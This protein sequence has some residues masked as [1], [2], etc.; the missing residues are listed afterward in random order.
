MT[1]AQTFLDKINREHYTLHK[2]YEE[3]FWL[4]YMGDHSV[5]EKM[6]Q[7]LVLRDAFRANLQHL[8]KIEELLLEADA[9]TKERLHIWKEYFAHYQ[10]TPKASALKIR[11]GKLEA[12]VHKKLAKR[13]EGYVDPYTQKFVKASST[14]M[15]TLTR[16]HDDERVRKACFE[17][18][19]GLATLCIPEYIQ[20]V[21]LRNEYVREKGY[22]DFYDYKL[23]AEDKITKKELFGLFDTLYTKTKSSFGELKKLAKKTPG[24]L[25]PW[26]FGYYMTGDFTKEEDPYFQF[27]DALL[28]WGR[29]FAAL[30]IDFKGAELTL[31][32]L[33]REGKYS[34]G[35]CHWPKLVYYKDGVRQSGAAGFTCNVVPGQVGAGMIGYNT[36]FH[37][38][39]HA[40]HLT[41]TEERECCLNHEYY[42]STASWDE[43]QSMFCDTM[44]DSIEW[45]TRYAKNAEGKTY[46]LDLHK[47]ILEKTHVLAPLELHSIAFVCN[48]ERE[49]YEAQNLTPEAV[50]EI[51]RKNYRKFNGLEEDS[52]AALNVPHIYS[53]ES[54]ASYH[55]YG[56]AQLAVYQW[57]EYFYTKYGYIVDN[58][59]VGKEMQKVWKYGGRYTFPKFVE[60]ATGKPLSTDAFLL[61]A[62]QPISEILKTAEERI[63]RLKKVK[64]YT[65]PVVLNAKIRLVDGK[66]EIA[67]NKRGFEKMTVTY[68]GWLKT[69]IT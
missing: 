2:K 52:L 16:T 8:T 45:R 11:I 30:G 13:K 15:R 57:R 43:V 24:L 59:K 36:L 31:D 48:F 22:A 47:R 63:A 21:A 42:P 67:N 9:K 46:P 29:S 60:M 23:Q 10:E 20:L 49:I 6:G 26:N 5:D 27:S 3:L 7:A 68:A 54:S 19:E 56:L 4:S 39:G 18:R 25:K 58:P 35:F 40:A 12:L 64:E 65:K 51:A 37:E 69:K 28:N 50:K 17:A 66:K 61:L 53:W 62:T 55:G 38:G 44:Y 14:K 34:N 41:N 1:T 33:D 32:L